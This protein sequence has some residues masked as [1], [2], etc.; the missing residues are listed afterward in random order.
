MNS[1]K[2]HHHPDLSE[3]KPRPRGFH[4]FAKAW[5]YDRVR[6]LIDHPT[7]PGPVNRLRRAC[8]GTLEVV[9][10][11]LKFNPVWQCTVDLHQPSMLALDIF[12]EQCLSS[13]VS[14]MVTYA[15][16]AHDLIFKH[17]AAATDYEAFL[18][19]RLVVRYQ[20]DF[21]N[22]Y[23]ATSY[24]N[25]RTDAASGKRGRVVVAYAD[26]P[27]KLHTPNFGHPCA[28]LECR[29]TGSAKLAAVGLA[30]VG[31]LRNFDF[32]SF[33]RSTL[34]LYDLPK[35]TEIGKLIGGPGGDEVSGTALRKRGQRF[36]DASSIQGQFYMHNAVRQEPFLLRKLVGLSNDVL[37]LPPV[38]TAVSSD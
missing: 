12:I 14:A 6:V 33:W 31:D 8:G 35:K 7:L 38:M 15:E 37:H 18:L 3:G 4:P 29:I 13:Q 10:G 22:R 25:S 1:E 17:Q 21:V 36:L 27:T 24:Y 16:I 9:P 30:S 2:I 19:E 23:A 5:G 32:G 28:H 26:R 11:R 34:S 20:R